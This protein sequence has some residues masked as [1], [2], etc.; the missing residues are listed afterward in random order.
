MSRPEDSTTTRTCYVLTDQKPGTEVA[1]GMASALGLG[2]I[3]FKDEDPN[4]SSMLL[5]YAEKL[6]TFGNTYKGKYSDS[7]QDAA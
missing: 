5:E 3:L 7:I 6:Y 1:A 2:S 4:Y